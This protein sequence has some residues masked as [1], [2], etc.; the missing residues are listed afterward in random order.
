MIPVWIHRQREDLNQLIGLMFPSFQK[1]R[2]MVS[3]NTSIILARSIGLRSIT[4]SLGVLGN[5]RLC[6]AHLCIKK[7]KILTQLDQYFF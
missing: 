3:K 1:D 6:L 4:T 2:A 7:K 5:A